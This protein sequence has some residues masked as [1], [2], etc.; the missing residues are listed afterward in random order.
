L[1]LKL[2]G[3]LLKPEPQF[4]G[5]SEVTAISEQPFLKSICK[6]NFPRQIW[7]GWKNPANSRDYFVGVTQ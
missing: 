6:N 5:M 4:A 7:S 2:Q 1:R 3:V